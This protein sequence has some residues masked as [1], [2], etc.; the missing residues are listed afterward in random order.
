VPCASK[1]RRRAAEL[2][3]FR[4][5]TLAA[6]A[7][8]VVVLVTGAGC[9]ASG[10]GGVSPWSVGSG[11][12]QAWEQDFTRVVRE[13]LPSIVEITSQ[14]GIGS[15]VIFDDEGDVVTNAHVVGK[16]TTF[17][18]R[19]STGTHGALANLNSEVI[20]IPTVAVVNPQLGG[21][22]PASVS[23]S[24]ATPRPTWRAGSSRTAASSTPGAGPG[25]HRPTAVGT[26]RP[27]QTHRHVQI[28]VIR[29]PG[30]TKTVTV[31]LAALAA[32]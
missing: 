31:T 1:N 11:G 27:T 6:L 2:W 25:D 15:G 8:L 28:T 29:P 20:G 7:A 17:Q 24:P 9:T 23:R 18:V 21:T 16:S 30:K 4:G 22:A 32:S 26:A 3:A 14:S 12:G 5:R 10:A 19:T 13:S